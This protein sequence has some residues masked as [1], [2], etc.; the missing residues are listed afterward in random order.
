[1]IAIKDNMPKDLIVVKRSGQ[2]V[3]FNPLKIA[4]AI[5][6]AFDSV[7]DNYSNK[8]INIVYNNTLKYIADNYQDRKTINV[9]DVQDIIEKILKDYKYNSVYESFSSYRIRRS[10][11]RKNFQEK[12]QH[13]FARAIEKINYLKL[14]NIKTK[15]VLLE[16]GNIIA[17]EYTKAYVL[18]NKYVRAAHEG[19]I[20]I[21]NMKYF[22]YGYMGNTFLD[23]SNVLSDG[24]FFD[25]INMIINAAKEIKGEIGIPAFDE[26]LIKNIKKYYQ[27]TFI[28]LLNKYLNNMG[29]THLIGNKKIEEKILK[30]DSFNIDNKNYQEIFNNDILKIILNNANTDAKEYTYEYYKHNITKMFKILNKNDNT[31]SISFGNSKEFFGKYIEDIIYEIILENKYFDN[32]SFIYKVSDDLTKALNLITANKNVKL[33]FTNDLDEYFSDG[34]RIYEN[35]YSDSIS[36]G[37]MNV[38]STSINIARLGIKYKK[39]NDK[40]YQEL[41]RLIDLVK[42]ELML[43]FENIGDKT[44]DNYDYLFNKNIYDSDK[45]DYGQKIRKVIKNGTLNINLS[46]LLECAMTIDKENY[47]D[48]AIKIVKYINK[49]TILMSLD[50][51]LNFTLSHIINVSAME[52][53]DIDASIFGNISNNEYYENLGSISKLDKI[54]DYNKINKLFTGGFMLDIIIDSKDYSEKVKKIISKLK[55]EYIGIVSIR[56]KL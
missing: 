2:R 44:K 35:I 23:I 43:V 22:N 51:K 46:G 16:Y 15:N 30:E 50:N 18:D 4:I 17:H 25:A 40:F 27:D 1:M 41:D 39:L 52:F 19:K 29:F 32:I 33:N 31:I 21:H 13:K 12:Q 48:I 38:S 6:N 37:R 55:K 56:R 36:S 3:T 11:S 7:P 54:A 9:E 28:R 14:D 10:E 49:K 26:S 24:D 20:Y 53:M 42:N 8:D 5:K 47:L 34:S 45:L